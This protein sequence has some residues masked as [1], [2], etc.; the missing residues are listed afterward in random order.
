M[1]VKHYQHRRERECSSTTI[2]VLALTVAL[3]TLAL[4]PVDIFLVS[5]QKLSSDGT[6]KFSAAQV[7]QSCIHSSARSMTTFLS[8]LFFVVW[9]MMQVGWNAHH[10]FSCAL[11]FLINT[12][13]PAK[14]TNKQTN[15]QSLCFL[16]L[17]VFQYSSHLQWCWCSTTP[18]TTNV[19]TPVHPPVPQVSEAKDLTQDAY[20]TMYA[21]LL[22]FAFLLLPMAYFYFE[23]KDEEA[24]TTCCTRFMVAI[25][26]T[27]GFLGTS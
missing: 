10:L 14:Q 11:I 23:E 18:R 16:L 4:V 19:C 7:S 25:K 5:Q 27:A 2:A 22:L 8:L 20:Y 9:K 21:F 17:A 12:W 1:Y 6:Y 26:Y 15:K 13:F 3:T 24:G